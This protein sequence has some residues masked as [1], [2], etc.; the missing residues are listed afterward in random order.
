MRT[1]TRNAFLLTATAVALLTAGLWARTQGLPLPY[2]AGVVM[3]V[4]I[5][6][7]AGV[8]WGERRRSIDAERRDA[9]ER[10]PAGRAR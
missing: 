9:M 3:S 10:H 4:P 7:L 6:M 1:D 2:L 5:G 8:A